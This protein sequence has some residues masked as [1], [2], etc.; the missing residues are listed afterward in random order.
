MVQST[1]GKGKVQ[2]WLLSDIG[3]PSQGK[4]YGLGRYPE[5]VPTTQYFLHY[6]VESSWSPLL[7]LSKESENFLGA[8]APSYS[9]I[10]KTYFYSRHEDYLD[11]IF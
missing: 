3:G 5:I 7:F 6:A 9:Y 4:R 1:K 10:A 11:H 2:K 8:L